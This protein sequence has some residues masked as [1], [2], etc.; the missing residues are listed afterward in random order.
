MAANAPRSNLRNLR[1]LR[2]CPERPR[3]NRRLGVAARPPGMFYGR[4]EI[5][6]E[7]SSRPALAL[8]SS[9]SLP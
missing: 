8:A 9:R 6:L 4:G 5:W 7:R 2:F 3:E 1:N